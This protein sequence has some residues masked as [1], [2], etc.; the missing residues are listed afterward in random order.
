MLFIKIGLFIAIVLM[1]I[2]CLYFIRLDW[3]RYGFLYLLSAVSANILCYMLTFAGFYSFPNNLLHGNLL[4]PY[5]LVSTAFPLAVLTGVRFG[6]EKWVWKIPFYWAIIHIGTLFEVV[7][8]ATPIFVFKPEWDLWDSY[9]LRW[10]YYL[11][12]EIVGGK[13]IPPSLR[14]PILHESFRYG[15]WAWIVLH[16]I[17]ISTIFLAGVYV[18]ATVF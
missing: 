15:R 7:L 11:L 1:G 12:F 14:K 4:I 10:V 18:G 5:A 3:K 16:I 9:S 13:I 17:L 8:L 2:C 6:P